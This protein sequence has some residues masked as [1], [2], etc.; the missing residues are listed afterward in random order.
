MVGGSFLL[1][2]LKDFGLWLLA[3][4]ISLVAGAIGFYL[5]ISGIKM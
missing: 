2:R 5:L 3:D 1:S 4:G